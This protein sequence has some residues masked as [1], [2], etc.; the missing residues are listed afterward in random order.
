MKK[1]SSFRE[2]SDPKM[3]CYELTVYT[4]H[5]IATYFVKWLGKSTP[6]LSYGLALSEALIAPAMPN[7]MARAGGVFLPI[8]KSLTFSWK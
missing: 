1:G 2:I 5:R 6:G 7:T 4:T 3:F 8:I